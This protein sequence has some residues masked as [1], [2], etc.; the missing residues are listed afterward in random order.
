M[1]VMS[2]QAA[3]QSSNKQLQRT[4]IPQHVAGKENGRFGASKGTLGTYHDSVAVADLFHVLP[5]GDA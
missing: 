1:T 3:S 5:V 2:D 4:V